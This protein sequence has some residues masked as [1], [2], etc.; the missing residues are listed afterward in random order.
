MRIHL[1]TAYSKT[2]KDHTYKLVSNGATVIPIT[3]VPTTRQHWVI[4]AKHDAKMPVY[5]EGVVRSAFADTLKQQTLEYLDLQG[6]YSEYEDVKDT[7]MVKDPVTQQTKVLRQHYI[8]YG[9][10]RRRQDIDYW[11]TAALDQYAGTPYD[12]FVT[13]FRF[14]NEHTY[15][16]SHFADVTTTRLYR[17]AV[18]VAPMT[19]TSE[20]GVD[21][22]ETDY[23]FV[24][25]AA[26]FDI[27]V[28]VFPQYTEYKP[29]WV[30]VE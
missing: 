20:H 11:C 29:L 24:V 25:D 8:D 26:D 13:D 6:S 16:G 14:P 30:M 5:G 22:L 2:G 17:S 27:A 4:Y 7:L 19:V 18:A 10:F 9:A 3:Q 15:T 21:D 1:T 12:V 23:L 28:K